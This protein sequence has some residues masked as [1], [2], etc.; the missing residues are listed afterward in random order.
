MTQTPDLIDALVLEATPV[1]R[2]R[3]PALRTAGWLLLA[4]AIIGGL[5]L[6]HGVRPDLA[7]RL[8]QPG[9]RIGIAASLLTGALAALAAF[10]TSL[11]DRSRW[12]L[13][14]PV[15]VAV[16]WISTVSYGCLTDWVALDAG[17]FQWG[18]A[19]SCF[20]TLLLSS[21]PLSVPMFWMLRHARRLR[22][23]GPML[24]G[25]VAVGA[26]TAT[27]LSLLHEYDA[28]LMILLWNF[29]AAALV[30]GVDAAIGCKVVSPSRRI[31]FGTA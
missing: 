27:A 9:F 5:A 13:L 21:I 18:E 25:C 15:P 20:A 23:T 4:L 19:A 1:A 3:S 11:P 8:R 10:V 2:L 17:S 6:L 22:P 31:P 16:L 24:T 12:W 29:G 28:S 7:E 26:L 30:M 14:L